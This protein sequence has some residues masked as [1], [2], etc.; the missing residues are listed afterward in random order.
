MNKIEDKSIENT[1]DIATPLSREEMANWLLTMKA[2]TDDQNQKNI[3]AL[4]KGIK[5]LVETVKESNLQTSKQTIF[6]MEEL[7]NSNKE[8]AKKIELLE[9][10]VRKQTAGMFKV[11]EGFVTSIAPKPITTTPEK[12]DINPIFFSNIKNPNIEKRRNWARK[13]EGIIIS[14]SERTG[15]NKAAIYK[16]IY[17]RMKDKD[18][19]D[20][21]ALYK[22]YKR[23]NPKVYS[24]I[25]MCAASDPLVLSFEKQINNLYYEKVHMSKADQIIV[26]MIG[27]DSTHNIKINPKEKVKVEIATKAGGKKRYCT[28]SSYTIP[29]EISEAVKKYCGKQKINSSDYQRAYD[30]FNK[31]TGIDVRLHTLNF[32]KKEKLPYCTIGF[33]I[34]ADPELRK[35]FVSFLSK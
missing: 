11:S 28:K 33:A 15:M 13:S 22:E 26:D 1:V 16:E 9:D 18:G 5:E 30:Y 29:A 14:L 20:V 6:W 32:S 34:Y 8:M 23:N 24:K 25:N 12:K 3:V 27:E 35:K 7:T 4:T 17:S 2:I 10:A 21:G 19:Y 31:G